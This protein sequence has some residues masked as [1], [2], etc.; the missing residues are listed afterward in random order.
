MDKRTHIK[1]FGRCFLFKVTYKSDRN[2]ATEEETDPSMTKFP[3]IDFVFGELPHNH[4]HD[5]VAQ[6]LPGKS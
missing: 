3:Q 1:S 2:Q 4:V 6:G 5:N